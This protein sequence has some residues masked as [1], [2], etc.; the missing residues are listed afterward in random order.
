[1]FNYATDLWLIVVKKYCLMI[2]ICI[3]PFSSFSERKIMYT[4]KLFVSVIGLNEV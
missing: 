3:S 1:V 2:I 4:R